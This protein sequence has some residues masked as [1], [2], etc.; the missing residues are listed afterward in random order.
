[1]SLRRTIKHVANSVAWVMV[2]PLGA[3]SELERRL[4]PGREGIFRLAAQTLA[5][6]PGEPGVYLRRAF[7][8]QAIDACDVESHISFGAILTHRSVIVERGVYVGPWALVGSAWLK[9]GTSVGSR[10][11]LLSGSQLHAYAD[12]R[13]TAYDHRKLRQISL[14]PHA[15]V[16]EG[17]IVMNDVGASALVSTGAV[18][19]TVVPAGVAVAGNPARFVRR[20]DAERAAGDGE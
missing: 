2:V 15:L 6:C 11:S 8:R 17:A 20:L 18:V 12:G 9:E 4:F 3:A 14:G 13:W 1:M 5:L 10:A 19:S 7:Y 16:G